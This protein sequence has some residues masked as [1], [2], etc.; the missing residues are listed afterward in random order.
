MPL[1]YPVVQPWSLFE[2][3]VSNNG[4]AALAANTTYLDA[5]VLYTAVTITGMVCR[6]NSANTGN[7]DMGI[8]DSGGNLLG[9]T[10]VT[11][12]AANTNTVNLTANL[13]LSAG[14]YYLALWIDNATA[15]M[16]RNNTNSSGLGIILVSAGTNAG[17]LA[18][19]F[20]GMGG[21][22]QTNI[23]PLLRAVISGGF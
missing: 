9:H 3:E 5:V 8:Y 1:F 19:T 4:S 16:V 18:S 20:A 2:G 7:I 12:L 17:G 10:G 13:A 6:C 23:K 15:V 11:A 22:A 21:T 14:R